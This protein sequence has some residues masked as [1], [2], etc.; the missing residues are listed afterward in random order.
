MGKYPSYS[1]K[2]WWKRSNWHARSPNILCYPRARTLIGAR[3]LGSNTRQI[4]FDSRL[5]NAK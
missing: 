3:W 1:V 4:G 5:A 2:K